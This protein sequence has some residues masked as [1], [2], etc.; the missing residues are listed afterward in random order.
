MCGILGCLHPPTLDARGLGLEMLA[1]IRYRGPDA[2]YLHL[3]AELFLAVRRLAIVN[4]SNG[5]QPAWSEDGNVVAVFNG[6]I[7]NHV[8]LKKQLVQ[9]GHQ[10]ADGSDVEVIPHAYEEWGLDFPS[11]FNGDFA[12]AVW[13]RRA[14]HLVLARDRLGIKPLYYGAT[15][16]GLVFASEIKAL[17]VHPE[18]KRSLDRQF[19]GQ[20]FTFWTGLDTGSPFEGIAQVE[21]G[22]IVEFSASGQRLRGRKYWDIPYHKNVPKYHG[23]FRSCCEAFRTE[24]RRSMKLRLRA[25]VEVGTYTSGGIDSAVINVIASG[26]LQRRNTQT[27]SV[28]FEDPAF[29]ESEHQSAV[30]RQLGLKANAVRCGSEDIYQRFADVIYH[31]EAPIFRTAPAAMFLLSKRVSEL[32]VKVV[33]TGEGADEIAWGYDIFREAKVRRFWSRQPD[34]AV[35]PQLF[36][37]LYAYLPQFQNTRHLALLVDFFR[38]D[39]EQ[40]DCP[41]YS[42]QTRMANSIATHVLL[43]ADLKRQLR[44]NPPTDALVAS[45]PEDFSQ[46]TLL[47]KC[48]YLEMRTLLQGYLLSSQGDRMLSAHGVEGR[49]PFL[50]HHVIE[51]LAGTPERY[52]LRGLRDKVLVRETFK[53]DLPQSIFNRPKFAFRAPEL[54]VFVN[55]PGEIVR[56][57]LSEQA[58]ADGG[59]FDRTAVAQFLERLTRTPPE[60]FSTRDNLAF[61]QILSTQILHDQVIRRF[62]W[63]KAPM[64]STDVTITR[65]GAHGY[66]PRSR[67]TRK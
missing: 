56:F 3:E 33:L 15:R 57:Y 51:F 44:E 5:R 59:I 31:T 62:H 64:T 55:D 25:D 8:D 14:R 60:R 7:Y 17:L 65:R 4:V 11:R 2:G 54:K 18:V 46:R 48:Q 41:L 61:V 45:L 36:K 6:E 24:L 16:E 23:D 32:G 42:H 66:G 39:M 1:Q 27:F 43:G 63:L 50:D 9:A 53:H 19:L 20:L 40:T 47:E 58:V 30:V 13:D 22:A 52:R 26:D 28:A 10:V 21:A 67:M 38:R 49:F 35:R 37:K 29:D 12:I 34:S